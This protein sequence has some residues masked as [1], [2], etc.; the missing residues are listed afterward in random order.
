[1][2]YK[3][4]T[5]LSVDNVSKLGGVN[6]KTN[7][8]NPTTMEGYYLGSRVVKTSTG[9]STI[10]AFQTS[11]GNAGLWGTKDL[12]DKLSQIPAGTMTLVEYT[13]KKKLAGGKTLITYNVSQDPE[14]RIDFTAATVTASDD[15]DSDESYNDDAADDDEDNSVSEDATQDAAML[16]AEAAAKKARVQEI[17]NRNKVARK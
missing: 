12:N 5:D 2:A 7:K 14:Q 1:M 8:S 10:H 15:S 13:G 4:V 11:K 17:L 6:A 16:A 3:L 9:E